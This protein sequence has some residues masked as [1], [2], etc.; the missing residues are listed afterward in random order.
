MN[1][2]EQVEVSRKRIQISNAYS[3]SLPFSFR[4]VFVCVGT[5]MMDVCISACIRE[6]AF[7]GQ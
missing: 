2:E 3:L 7:G 1:R 6:H 4:C 5:C